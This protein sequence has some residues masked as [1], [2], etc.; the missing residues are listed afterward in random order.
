MYIRCTYTLDINNITFLQP[1]HKTIS[2]IWSTPTNKYSKCVH[3]FK[4]ICLMTLS[5]FTFENKRRRKFIRI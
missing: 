5:P 2:T 1:A 4:G 3:K